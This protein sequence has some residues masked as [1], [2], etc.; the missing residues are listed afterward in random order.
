MP[1]KIKDEIR[2]LYIKKQLNKNY[3]IYTSKLVIHWAKIGI[4]LNIK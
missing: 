3:S 1:M 2:F 4:A